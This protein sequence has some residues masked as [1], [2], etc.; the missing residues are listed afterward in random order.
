MVATDRPAAEHP[1]LNLT[2]RGWSP[3]EAGLSLVSY[4]GPTDDLAPQLAT[5]FS[6]SRLPDFSSAHR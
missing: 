4:G 5:V 2:I 6:P 3:T 1:D